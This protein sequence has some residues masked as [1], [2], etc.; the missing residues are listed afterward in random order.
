MDQGPIY[1]SASCVDHKLWSPTPPPP[2][3]SAFLIPPSPFCQIISLQPK[4]SKSHGCN[5]PLATHFP[6]CLSRPAWALE[7]WRVLVAETIPDGDNRCLDIP[8]LWFF[9]FLNVPSQC[10]SL[11]S[12]TRFTWQNELSSKC[13]SSVFISGATCT[14]NSPNIVYNMGFLPWP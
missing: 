10:L 12:N 3:T 14:S 8:G 1:E 13:D 5:C 2:M 4:H 11:M 9:R 6:R 7:A